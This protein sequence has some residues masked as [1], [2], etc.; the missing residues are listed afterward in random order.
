M[1]LLG[2]ITDNSLWA[3][4]SDSDKGLGFR[5]YPPICYQ[6]KLQVHCMVQSQL[7]L[8]NIMTDLLQVNRT[9]RVV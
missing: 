6:Y 2:I 1:T 9:H 7:F 4:W 5:E 8:I 3:T